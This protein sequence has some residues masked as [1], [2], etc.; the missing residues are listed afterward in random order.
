METLDVLV[1][2]D[3][4]GIR[5]GVSRIL[6]NFS[7]S[8]PFMDDDIQFN[9]I[10]AATGE[11]ALEIINS[12]PPAIVLLDNKLPGMQGIEVLD[13]INNNHLDILVTMITS[14]ASLDL[15]V[16]ATNI[17]AYDFVPK[18]FTPQ[19]LKAS[20]ENIAKHYFLRRMTRKLHKEGKQVRFQFLTVLS[21]ELK[22]P[23]NAIEGYLQIMQEKQAGES[24]EAYQ[25]MIER[26]LAR[27]K[28]M[29]SL[30]MDLL[31]LTRIESGKRKREFSE[32]DLGLVAKSAIDTMI[33]LAVQLDVN[34]RL[35]NNLTE[36]FMADPEEMEI[37]FNNL[38]SNAVKYNKTGGSVVCSLSNTHQ[39]LKIVIAD[40]GYGI[41][42]NDIP[43]LFQEFSRIHNTSTKNVSGSGLGLS[44]VKRIVE[45]YKGNIE[46]QSAINEGSTFIVTLPLNN[47]VVDIAGI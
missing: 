12:K 26:S 46:V 3:E 21:H 41:D 8:Y 7:V 18:P 23:L 47:I 34:I 20:L 29:R 39:D 4:P 16:K 38:I 10:E 25:E 45:I 13:Y 24:I 6:R 28:S 33:P 32:L 2:D 19:E 11:E 44:I 1:V 42:I 30:I 40:T 17:G 37:I 9:I 35:E 14:Y 5:S 27:I 31:D 15:A 36:S 22:S 43:K